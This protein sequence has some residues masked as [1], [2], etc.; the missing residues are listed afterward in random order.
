MRLGKYELHEVISKGGFGAIY[1]A[2]ELSLECEVIFK[3]KINNLRGLYAASTGRN[4]R[5]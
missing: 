1:L 2:S 5:R 4:I 3:V